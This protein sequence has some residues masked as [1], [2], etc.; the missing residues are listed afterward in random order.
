MIRGFQDFFINASRLVFT[1]TNDRPK[2]SKKEEPPREEERPSE[3]RLAA[4]RKPR[5]RVTIAPSTS[6]GPDVRIG[7]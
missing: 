6:P 2:P 7:P 4:P 1:K 5:T 3:K